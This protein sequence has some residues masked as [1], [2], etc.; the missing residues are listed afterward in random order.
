MG[1]PTSPS[2]ADGVLVASVWRAGAGGESVVRL[3]MTRPGD[4][5]ETV[6]TVSSRA[7]ALACVEEWLATLDS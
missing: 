7:E 5:G 4:E 1:D 2:D 6:R 3:T